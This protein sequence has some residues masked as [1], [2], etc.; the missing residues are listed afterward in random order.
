MTPAEN[1]AHYLEN[2]TAQHEGKCQTSSK[3]V[4]SRIYNSNDK[5]TLHESITKAARVLGLRSSLVSHCIRGRQR[6]TGGYEFRAADVFK[7]LPGEQWREVDVPALREEKRKRMHAQL[8]RPVRSRS[9]LLTDA[10]TSGLAELG[11]WTSEARVVIQTNAVHEGP[12]GEAL[13]AAMGDGERAIAGRHRLTRVI[14]RM[15]K[16]R[17]RVS[18]HCIF[19]KPRP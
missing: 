9:M 1:R 6:Q 3:P 17:S 11:R 10:R 4:W 13:P 5:W 8:T 7:S 2:R 15:Q 16:A 14:F 12:A 19:L 18:S